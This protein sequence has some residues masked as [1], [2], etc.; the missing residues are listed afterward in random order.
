MKKSS[1]QNEM[2]WYNIKAV[3]RGMAR[4]T[5]KFEKTCKKD[6][7]VVDK[8]KC[9]WYNKRAVSERGRQDLEN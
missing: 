3:S 5:K 6:K 2:V 7:K 9:V 1:W 4:Y 8:R